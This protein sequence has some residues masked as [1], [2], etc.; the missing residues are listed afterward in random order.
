MKLNIKKGS[1]SQLIEVF[2]SDSSKTDGSGL[3]GVAFGDI[4]G[5]YYR[6]GAAVPVQ[7]AALKTMTVGTWVTEGFKEISAANMPGYYQL[8]VPN[9]ALITGTDKVNIMLKGATN[10]APLPLEIQLINTVGFDKNVAF[11]NFMFPMYNSNGVLTPGLT[12]TAI[13][14][15]DGAAFV[16]AA[17]AV[18]EISNG[19]YKINL[20]TSDLNGNNILFEFSAAGARTTSITIVTNR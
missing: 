9:A 14:A 7:L 12:V 15:I 13:R 5:Y 1:T 3:T 18:F 6:S 10:M 16:P 17:N 4:T 11:N 8:G 2:I 19:G 20:A